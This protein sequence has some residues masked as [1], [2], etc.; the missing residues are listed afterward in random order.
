MK[1]INPITILAL[2]FGLLVAGGLFLAKSNSKKT[3]RYDF[4]FKTIVPESTCDNGYSGIAIEALDEARDYS[5]R[6]IPVTSDE[7]RAFS[8]KTH[9]KLQEKYPL[10]PDDPRLPKL[11]SILEKMSP[12]TYSD[13]GYNV[14]VVQKK[15]INAFT[16]AGGNIYFTT[17]MLDFLEN[18]DELA[19]VMGHEIGHNENGHCIEYLKKLKQWEQ[20]LP[21]W[22]IWDHKISDLATSVESIITLSFKQ[23]AENC[24]DLCGAYLCHMGGFDPE[25]GKEIFAKFR[26][27]ERSEE[28]RLADRFVRSH[29]Y[30]DERYFCVNDYLKLAAKNAEKLSVREKSLSEIMCTYKQGLLYFFIIFSLLLGFSLFRDFAAR[31]STKNL[32][33]LVFIAYLAGFVYFLSLPCFGWGEN[34]NN[35]APK[36]KE[37]NKV[38]VDKKAKVKTKGGRLSLRE[39]PSLEASRITMMP[40]ES[41]L[42]CI[43]CCCDDKVDDR[44]GKWCYVRYNG[45]EGYAWGWYIQLDE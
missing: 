11:Q 9:Q 14:Y 10:V 15:E 31:A 43:Y 38:Y 13:L 32:T 21:E 37:N 30:S 27:F 20:L 17:G 44:K 24:A 1:K 33:G 40:P 12:Y 25:K 6:A 35:K 5:L 7:V 22:E 18:D 19:M 36:R 45:K 4:P 28:R 2:V 29:P 34:N 39:E 26:T 3:V 8:A 23:P 42:D 41:E 16:I